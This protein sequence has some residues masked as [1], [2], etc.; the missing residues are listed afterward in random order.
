MDMVANPQAGCFLGTARQKIWIA[1]IG[2][3]RRKPG[4]DA[5]VGLPLPSLHETDRFFQLR[6]AL[7]P[8]DSPAQVG[9]RACLFHRL[10]DPVHLKV[11]IRDAG[12]ASFD[13]L[14]QPQHGT[15][16][17]ILGGQVR[18]KRKDDLVKPVVLIHIWS[19]IAEEYHRHVRVRVNHAWHCQHASRVDY[20]IIFFREGRCRLDSGDLVALDQDILTREKAWHLPL[21][22]HHFTI[23]NDQLC[24][25]PCPAFLLLEILRQFECVLDCP[26]KDRLYVFP[27]QIESISS[28]NVKA[29]DAP[30]L[31]QSFQV[32]RAHFK[33]GIVI[34]PTTG[35]QKQ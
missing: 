30:K 1:E 6:I 35:G 29:R 15:P 9:A 32:S 16:I 34:T 27:T 5:T 26:V 7:V 10:R 2:R 4:G 14:C 12:N 17:D 11:M 21:K 23:F 19:G 24:H 20:L 13:H 8:E 18:F 31:A 33:R 22:G 3:M 28:H 25:V